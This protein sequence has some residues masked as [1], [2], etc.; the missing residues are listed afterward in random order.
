[1]TFTRQVSF[2]SFCNDGLHV[3]LEDDD[4]GG[5]NCVLARADHQTFPEVY[6]VEVINHFF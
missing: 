2:T 4:E 3:S 5:L 6:Y 1:L